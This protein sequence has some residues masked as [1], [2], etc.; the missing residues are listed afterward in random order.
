MAGEYRLRLYF[1]NGRKKKNK[2]RI[3]NSNNAEYFPF[4]F[5]MQKYWYDFYVCK[6]VYINISFYLSFLALFFSPYWV[7]KS[8]INTYKFTVIGNDST[9]SFLTFVSLAMFLF[10]FEIRFLFLVRLNLRPESKNSQY[11]HKPLAKDSNL[12]FISSRLVIIFFI[13]SSSSSSLLLPWK[14]RV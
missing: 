11:I 3:W 13:H 4:P 14:V 8:I 7:N 12:T 10:Q 9:Q 6:N 1:W 5:L 2:Y